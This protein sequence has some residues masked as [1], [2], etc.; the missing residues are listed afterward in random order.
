MDYSKY[1][2]YK[3]NPSVA[4][5]EE[6]TAPPSS[7]STIGK[8]SKYKKE[9][10]I[11]A[12]EAG[13]TGFV[14]NLLPSA[15][16]IAGGGAAITAGAPLIAAS[17][18]F[19]PVTTVGLALAGG[20]TAAVGTGMVQEAALEEFAPETAARA[21]KAEEE[22]PYA[23]HGGSL[24][25]VAPFTGI[26]VKG[27][28]TLS[29]YKVADKELGMGKVVAG[30]A[31]VGA[32]FEAGSELA[33]GQDLDPVKIAMSAAAGPVT[34]G[35]NKMGN[36]L[37]GIKDTP[38]A[39]PTQDVP[40]DT[41][42]S[43]TPDTGAD[44]YTPTTPDE[45]VMKWDGEVRQEQATRQE[46]ALP[47][48][49]HT[50]GPIM[51]G[52]TP[53]VT[54]KGTPRIARRNT[55][56]GEIF[57]DPEAAKQSWETSGPEDRPWIKEKFRT[58]EEYEQFLLQHEYEHSISPQ[59]EGESDI[60]YE[61][62]TSQAAEARIK[63]AAENL[64][65][66]LPD[67]VPHAA[68]VVDSSDFNTKGKQVLE[69]HGPEAAKKFAEDFQKYREDNYVNV[70]RPEGD[71]AMNSHPFADALYTLDT[72][73]RRDEAQLKLMLDESGKGLAAK[74][75]GGEK[76]PS[77]ADMGITEERR[78]DW[79]AYL[80]GQMKLPESEIA[81][82]KQTIGDL[83][84]EIAALAKK[85]GAE[86][87]EDYMPRIRL[88]SPKGVKEKL[89]KWWGDMTRTEGAF[90]QKMNEGPDA[91]EE[92]NI[93][94]LEKPD[95]SRTVVQIRKNGIFSFDKGKMKVLAKG[96]T[97][98]KKVGDDLLGGKLVEAKV[99]EIE[100]NT[101]YR[102]SHDP[103]L[104]M[105]I[106]RNELRAEDRL[107]TFMKEMVESPEFKDIGVD[108]IDKTTGKPNK[109]IPAGWKVPKHIDRIPMLAGKAFEPK[110]AYILEDWAK[111]WDKS[112]MQNLTSFLIKNM[113]L[114]PI[115]HV[116]NEAMHLYNIRGATGWFTPGGLY[117]FFPTAKAGMR[118]VLNQSPLY[119]QVMKEG[120]SILGA[121]VRNKD[122]VRNLLDKAGKDALADPKFEKD[123]GSIAA[124]VGMTPLNLYNRW[125]KASNKF[126]WVTRDMMYM[127]IIRETM[128]RKGV[129]VKGAIKI[130]EKHMP[131]YRL[132]SKIMGSRKVSEVLGNPNVAVFSRYHYGMIRSL[133]ETAKEANPKNLKTPEGRKQFLH[134]LDVMAAVGIAY[135]ALYPIMDAMA[136]AAFG[137]EAEQRR[138]GPYHLIHAGFEV[139]HGDKDTQALLAPVFTFNPILLYT[140]QL[141]MNRQLYS[142]KEV[143]HPN[144]TAGQIATDIGKYTAK[145]IPQ[146]GPMQQAGESPEGFKKTL[147][148]QMDIKAKT[149]TDAKKRKRRAEFVE[150]ERKKRLR[151]Y[152]RGRE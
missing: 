60:D 138:A 69:K 100:H 30:T 6:G 51:D 91:L 32:G 144:D 56:T 106:R 38:T 112:L 59:K 11:S 25:S 110:I 125:S 62:R 108:V 57:L 31:G 129:D 36:K 88:W 128:K 12:T 136:K 118:D 16:A 7:S 105:M 113:M 42:P 9:D 74:T 146:Y 109:E 142:G 50:R 47:E 3:K 117:R 28:K 147:A 64:P 45:H 84:A 99:H 104:N 140:G 148:K 133:I 124:K 150:R 119:L 78:K 145:S 35:S 143:F 115:P 87:S 17:G 95:G 131:N 139:A 23:Y 97:A 81:V 116:F 61:T 90:A 75:V 72:M 107:N 114:N 86:L 63:K 83:Q 73:A 152:R 20:L 33:A 29:K 101:S 85:N 130:V 55:E 137:M 141:V 120:G 111:T 2:S 48:V 22:H 92:R 10:D 79:F 49:Q 94:A 102:Y 14:Q 121:D 71:P 58:P 40:S 126:M 89:G 123:L 134:S 127:Q 135:A 98:S 24:V 132:P 93:F 68:S 44:I 13:V 37:M 21:K 76:T 8:Y 151:D 65:P 1:S 122:F 4:V 67:E 54:D 39:K 34:L 26:G 103:V 96:E 77:L 82:M 66:V 43:D 18:P 53:A 41:P 70:P 46:N 15:A 149:H 52:E 27:L 80:D 19:A 5:E